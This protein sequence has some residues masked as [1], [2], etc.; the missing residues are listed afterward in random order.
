[1]E[2]D[3]RRSRLVCWEI[4][5]A[6]NTDDQLG[7]ASAFSP[8]PPLDK[9]KMLV[10]TMMN[11]YGDGNH[12]D[13]LIERLP[14]T[15]TTASPL[16]RVGRARRGAAAKNGNALE[17]ARRRK[18]RTHPELAGVGSRERLVVL[19]AEV[20]G[21]SLEETSE[22]NSSLGW[23]KIRGLPAELELEA[24]RAWLAAVKACLSLILSRW[25]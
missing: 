25:F 6:K 12:T 22:F 15:P 9:L 23:A 21:R 11:R 5:M 8:M 17:N 2:G 7:R 4:K 16:H 20:G 18:E 1:M 13:G 10:T 3:V 14:L 24:R 19:W